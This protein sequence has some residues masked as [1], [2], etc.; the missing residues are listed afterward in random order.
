MWRPFPGAIHRA[1]AA[2]TVHAERPTDEGIGVR[3]GAPSPPRPDG[4]AR[5]IVGGAIHRARAAAIRPRTPHGR[6]PSALRGTG[7]GRSP[8]RTCRAPLHLGRAAPAPRLARRQRPARRSIPRAPLRYPP[9]ACRRVPR[10]D[11][12]APR[13]RA[14]ARSLLANGPVNC[15]DRASPPSHGP[16]SACSVRIPDRCSSDLRARAPRPTLA[17][18]G[19]ARARARRASRRRAKQPE[20]APR[21]TRTSPPRRPTKRATGIAARLR[22]RPMLRLA[23]IVPL[24]R[25]RAPD[26]LCGHAAAPREPS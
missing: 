6:G 19:R 13:S 9:V 7:S 16:R 17:R 15:V 22:R 18:P 14:P 10:E 11:D 21:P 3:F 1:R 26:R 12:V 5:C 8:A 23:P 25:P 4:R 2:A 24:G 20:Q